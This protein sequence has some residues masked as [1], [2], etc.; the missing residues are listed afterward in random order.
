MDQFQ[1]KPRLVFLIFRKDSV[2]LYIREKICT[3]IG[4]FESINTCSKKESSLSSASTTVW[5]NEIRGWGRFTNFVS[6]K[7]NLLCKDDCWKKKPSRRADSFCQWLQTVE[8]TLKWCL[9]IEIREN[10]RCLSKE[11]FGFRPI[12]Y[13]QN[14]I[15]HSNYVIPSSCVRHECSWCMMQG[16][17]NVYLYLV[18]N[19]RSAFAMEKI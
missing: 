1:V 10:S 13:R 11:N 3:H 17:E 8:R 16:R 9:P 18:A 2:F 6:K 4:R 14:C 15:V 7:E 5:M 12:D 19:S